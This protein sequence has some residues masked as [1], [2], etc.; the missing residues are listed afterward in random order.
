ML[1]KHCILLLISQVDGNEF[2]VEVV[3]SVADYV[4][5]MKE[6]FD[7]DSLRELLKGSEGRKPFKILIDSMNGGKLQMCLYRR[8]C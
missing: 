4:G 7:F 5:L 8:I 3:D 1:F 2:N 6:I